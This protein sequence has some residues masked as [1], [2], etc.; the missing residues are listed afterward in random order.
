MNTLVLAPSRPSPALTGLREL[1]A[2]AA[3]MGRVSLLLYEQSS[4]VIAW[5]KSGTRKHYDVGTRWEHVQF[6]RHEGN[7]TIAVVVR[8]S[9]AA[10]A[11]VAA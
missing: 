10:W 3:A 9:D 4:E 7:V 5:A 8:C 2:Q 11:E 1:I 6:T